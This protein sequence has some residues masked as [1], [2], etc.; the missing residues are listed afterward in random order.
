MQDEIRDKSVALVI[1]VGKGGAKLTA[2]LLKAAMREYLK[3]K[4]E[5]VHGKQ[6]VKSLA[7]KEG[8][9]KS[10][11]V[12]EGN[13]KSFEKTARKYG[14]DF[15]VAKDSSKGHYVVFFRAR[16]AD[17]LNAA[18]SEY[19]ANVMKRQREKPSLLK[20]LAKMKEFVAQ[21]TGQEKNRSKGEQTR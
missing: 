9:L 12:T 11:E 10:I 5:P 8:G 15:A 6:S 16:D 17:A 4:N 2:E 13:I 1:K 14:I 19:T 7:G 21:M 20:Q 3:H 18:F